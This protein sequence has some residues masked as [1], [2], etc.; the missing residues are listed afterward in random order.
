MGI[1]TEAPDIKGF[2]VSNTNIQQGILQVIIK[3]ASRLL[4][5]LVHVA[6]AQI[7]SRKVRVF[8]KLR[9]ESV[10]SCTSAPELVMDTGLSLQRKVPT[11]T[12]ISGTH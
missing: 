11:K 3:S 4:V 12:F 6:N 7:S 5:T 1:Q 8:T 9:A 10:G 2:Q